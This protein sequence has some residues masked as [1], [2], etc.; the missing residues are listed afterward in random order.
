M[1]ANHKYDPELEKKLRAGV[2]Q[3]LLEHYGTNVHFAFEIKLEITDSTEE[4]E[5]ALAAMELMRPTD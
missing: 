3:I 1:A 4:S 2:N 5:A